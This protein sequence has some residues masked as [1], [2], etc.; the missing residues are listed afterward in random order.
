MYIIIIFAGDSML[1][2]LT[3]C[4]DINDRKT[5]AGITDTGLVNIL[6][7]TSNYFILLRKSVKANTAIFP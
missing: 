6:E 4:E 2:G 7:G 3:L 5:M 1:L